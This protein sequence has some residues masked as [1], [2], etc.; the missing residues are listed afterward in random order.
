MKC[1]H[2]SYII[3]Y[4]GTSW[5]I[6]KICIMHRVTSVY[7]SIFY[8]LSE[9]NLDE[10]PRCRNRTRQQIWCVLTLCSLFH[11]LIRTYKHQLRAV[12]CKLHIRIGFLFDHNKLNGYNDFNPRLTQKDKTQIQPVLR[13]Y[14]RVLVVD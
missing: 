9:W 2:Y 12:C 3:F 4:P 7:P 14:F 10:V 5:C 1:E 11:R 13:N 8:I 6:T